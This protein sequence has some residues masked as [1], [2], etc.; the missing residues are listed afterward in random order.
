[1]PFFK[2]TAITNSGGNTKGVIEAASVAAA[3]D[4]LAARG[5][6]PTGVA[7]TS[8]PD[9]GGAGGGFLTDLANR[10]QSIKP[11]DLILFTKQLRTMLNAGI[12]VLQSLD[13]LQN[14]TENPRLKGAIVSIGADIKSGTTLSKA[15]SKHTGVFPELYCNMIRA[16]EISG[17][18]T[19]VLERLI[20]IVEHE[21]KVKKDI[22]SA[23]TYPMVVVVALVA[24][25]FILILF[26]L[27][28]FVDLFTKAGI[29]LPLPTRICLGL[30]AALTKFWYVALAAIGGTVFALS[31][32]FR[33]EAGKIARDGFF[34]KLPI[35]GPVFKKAAMARFASIFAILQASGITVLEAMD[36]LTDTIG[37]AYIANDFRNLREKLE[38]GRGLSGPLRGAKSFTPMMIS[39]ITIGEETGNMEDMLR[40]AAKH[41]DY[42]VEYAVSKMSELLGPVLVAGL[43]G[44]VGFF[45]LAIFLPLVEL[46]QHSMSGLK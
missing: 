22:K 30:Y 5:L 46:M 35:L 25:F 10:M 16:G 37:N 19:E 40:E 1:M 23:L 20:Y 13:V 43:T 18:L 14:Q 8:G 6:I 21:F 28:Q 41:Y 34:L 44:V 15:F 3:E 39:M 4:Q 32:Y 12:P 29:A 33:T 9:G 11:Q 45:A 31:A 17:T 24:A 36:I 7:E 38:Q 2:Y 26:V 42:E 27:P